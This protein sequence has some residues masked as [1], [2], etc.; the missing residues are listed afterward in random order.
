MADI[1]KTGD[2]DGFAKMLAEAGSKFKA[3]VKKA[4]DNSGQL[5]KL[6]VKDR[7]NSGQVTP[8][9][10]EK[11]TKWKTKHGY[12]TDTLRMTGDLEAAIQYQD[13]AWN[14]GFVGVNRNAAGKD[15]QAL[16]PIARIMEY[17]PRKAKK[18][19]PKPFIRPVVEELGQ[20]V[21][22]YYQEAVEETFK[23]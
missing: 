23:K 5:I 13:I 2:W 22:E 21:V 16:V 7:I 20:K 14:E 4:T 15:G 17:G 18:G 19:L 9:T 12:S 1:E 3:N 6:R 10:S 11:F 8:K